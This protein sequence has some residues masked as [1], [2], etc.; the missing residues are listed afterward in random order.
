M[1]Q[2]YEIEEH[3]ML[4]DLPHIANMRNYWNAIFSC[5]QADSQKLADTAKPGAVRLEKADTFCLQIVFEY[6]S[7]GSMF[8]ESNRQWSYLLS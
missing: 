3:E 6:H 5:K 1:S 4:M 7:I 2:R 8:A